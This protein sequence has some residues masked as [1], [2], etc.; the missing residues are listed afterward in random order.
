MQV[1]YFDSNSVLKTLNLQQNKSKNFH[2]EFIEALN[3]CKILA[4]NTEFILD[5]YDIVISKHL[6][7]VKVIGQTNPVIR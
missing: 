7:N 5:Q 1:F 2:I 4:G 3:P 6:Q